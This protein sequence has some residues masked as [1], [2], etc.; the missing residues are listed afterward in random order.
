MKK[1]IALLLIFALSACNA[2]EETLTGNWENIIVPETSIKA[3]SGYDATSG[4]PTYT[5][6]APFNTSMY[7]KYF[8]NDKNTNNEEIKTNVSS[9]Y[10]NEISRLHKMFDRHYK[11][12]DEEENLITNVQTINNSYGTNTPIKCSDELYS[13]LKLGVEC[14]DLTNGYFNIFT[15]AITD[16]WEW[17]FEDLYNY[18]PLE[19]TD[20]YYSVEQKDLLAKY[21][22]QIPHTKDD[23]SK[24]LV[25]DDENKTV[26]FNKIIKDADDTYKPIIS[27]GGIAK[28]LANDYAKNLLVG[29][30]Y[31]DGILMSGASSITSLGKPIH[32][33][34]SSGQSISIINPEKST[35]FDSKAAFSMKISDEFCF[36]T[37]GNYTTNKSYSFYDDDNNLIY[38]HHILNPYTGYPESYHRSVSILSYSLSS[39]MVD[40]LTTAMMTLSLDD[41]LALRNSIISKG[42]SYYFD[43]FILDQEGIKETAKVTVHATSN[44]NSTLTALDG[45][46]IIYE[47]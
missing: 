36:S 5:T 10:I 24:Q 15:G 22:E 38:R 32:S 17:V 4:N 20:P 27:V 43:M 7:L 14:Y 47:K 33:D 25:F 37:S 12:L 30:G 23:I 16:Y 1:K 21:V 11:Y 39:A 3:F 46:E 29:N 31:K 9:L 13:L 28:G 42:E 26:T 34:K 8:F 6:V 44:V 41:C 18:E 45:V 19:S 35:F 40:V 2:K